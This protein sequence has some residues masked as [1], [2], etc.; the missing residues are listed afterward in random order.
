MKRVI[1]GSKNNGHKIKEKYVLVIEYDRNRKPHF[2]VCENM[3]VAKDNFPSDTQKQYVTM[4]TEGSKSVNSSEE[5]DID[6][7]LDFDDELGSGLSKEEIVPAIAE[8]TELDEEMAE[9][10]YDWYD[11][12]DA[13]DDFD[14][15]KDFITFMRSDLANMLDAC[16]DEELKEKLYREIPWLQ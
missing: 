15:V 7:E 8:A 11:A 3:Q 13:W 12:E 4:I 9:I 5:L 14:S 16:D 10:I 1:G 6:D 2:Y